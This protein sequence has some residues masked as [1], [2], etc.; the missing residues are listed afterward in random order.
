MRQLVAV[1]LIGVGALLASYGLV[2]AVTELG[3]LYTQVSDDPLAEPAVPEHE[4]PARI[5]HKAAFGGVGVLSLGL[6]TF[7]LK[8]SRRKRETETPDRTG[9]SP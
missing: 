5:L 8:S 2:G 4:R 7:L 6:G 9:R 1:I 3:S